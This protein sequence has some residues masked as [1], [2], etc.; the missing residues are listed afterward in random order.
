MTDT[1]D[2][3]NVIKY[4][5][6]CWNKV[7]TSDRNSR[8]PPKNTE[9]ILEKP[10]VETVIIKTEEPLELEGEQQNENSYFE[11]NDRVIKH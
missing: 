7:D 6:G 3:S 8:T 9:I 10:E 4:F 11:P 5:K 1:E 2:S